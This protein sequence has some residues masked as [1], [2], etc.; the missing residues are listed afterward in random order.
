MAVEGKITGAAPLIQASLIGEAV[1]NGPAAIF[2]A[3]EEMRYV[4]VNQF[5]ADLLGYTREELLALRVTD[6]AKEPDA[7]AH[8]AQMMTERKLAGIETLTRKDGTHVDVRWAA[9]ETRVAGMPVYVA[10]CVP[11]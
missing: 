6:V 3:D 1:D 4:A 2:V 11:V 7:E 8:Y 9:S 10:I 5:A